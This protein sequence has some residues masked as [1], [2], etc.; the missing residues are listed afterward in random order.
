MVL[1]KGSYVHIL[2]HVPEGQSLTGRTSRWVK[3]ATGR[4]LLA[5]GMVNTRPIPQGSTYL[6]ATLHYVLKGASAEVRA[7]LGVTR[8]GSGG[9]IL[10]KRCGGTLNIWGRPFPPLGPQG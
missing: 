6:M 3:L 7:V 10:G 5:K 4:R 8:K 1:A 2:L 9:L